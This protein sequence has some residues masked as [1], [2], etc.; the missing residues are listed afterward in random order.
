MTLKKRVTEYFDDEDLKSINSNE[1]NP[2]EKECPMCGFKTID[3]D[4]FEDHKSAHENISNEFWNNNYTNFVN[5]QLAN[6]KKKTGTE[7][8]DLLMGKIKSQEGKKIKGTLAYAGV[9]L[10]NRLYLPEQLAKGD[11]K[12]LPLIVNHA[13][14]SGAEGELHRLPDQ[15]REGLVNG[16]EM[17]VGTVKL[18]WDPNALTLYYSGEVDDEFFQKEIGEADMAVSL[19]MY[20]DADSPQVCDR[21]CYT[22][23]KGGE[24]SEVSL[25]YHAGFPIATIEANEAIL[26]R[27]GMEAL[28]FSRTEDP[29]KA[30]EAVGPH[31]PEYDQII[32]DPNENPTTSGRG[33]GNI[34]PETRVAQARM[35]ENEIGVKSKND[36]KG[37]EEVSGPPASTTPT[38]IREKNTYKESLNTN[39][40]IMSDEIDNNKLT[41]EP[42]VDDKSKTAE[43]DKED[44]EDAEE[45][46]SG[47]HSDG[48]GGN[49]PEGQIWDAE[50]ETCISVNGS[51]DK[52][53]PSGAKVGVSDG[54][55]SAERLARTRPTSY[56]R[57]SVANADIASEKRRVKEYYKKLDRLEALRGMKVGEARIRAKEQYLK[58]KRLDQL[59]RGA[60]EGVRPKA[61]VSRKTAKAGESFGKVKADEK[62]ITGP[63]RWY[64]AIKN[65]EN[66][67]NSFIW[68]V[69]KQGIFENSD[70]RFIKSYDANENTQY[71]PLTKDQKKSATEAVTGPAGNDFMRI[72]SEQ[73]LV[74][75][76]GKVVTPIRQFCETKVL[77][78]GTKEAFFYD[79]GAVGFSDI[80]EDGSTVVGESAVVVRSAGG[81]AGARGT[82]LI[83]GY[84]QIE[85]SPID[86]IASANRSFA[87]ESVNDESKEVVN[88]S[89]NTDSGSAGDATNRKAVGGGSKANRWVSHSGSQITADASG[90]GN[91]T[92]AGLVSAKGVIEDEGLDPS[93]LVTYTTGKAIRD[94]VFDPDLDSFIS[95]SRPAIITEAT[96]ERIAGTNVVRS[97]ALAS[98]SQSGSSRSV[99]FVPNIAFGLISG[100][101]LTMEAQRRNE[102]QSIFLTGTQRIAGFTKNVEAT[103]RI[104]HL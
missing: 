104:S 68:H 51:V 101:D 33:V 102:L 87:L 13:S 9:S 23:I 57:S 21:E 84:T 62:E 14:T 5:Y 54:G 8:V 98:G 97:S 92:F 19:G 99:M 36:L 73:V 1:V 67:P 45:Q 3:N 85:E 55:K 58:E 88:V 50:T 20:Y 35:D 74:L 48:G 78:T 41:A 77:P 103:C 81:P 49:C 15:V 90:L 43:Q 22:V 28:K 93:N 11:G 80:T 100:R 64:Q 56:R 60:K 17:Q 29:L 39:N 2:D 25:V 6:L 61:I 46:A 30:E 79:F 94:L 76:N 59:I 42:I 16:K 72:M 27:K 4:E 82:K 71:V 34:Q 40:K 47:V 86:L 83:L 10:N 65:E 70:Q 63:A 31:S 96:V 52:D 75:P 32:N 69:N 12:Q 95:F 37:E 24:F 53:A 89:F 66:V 44:K 91:L 18:S 26:R 7:S 38:V